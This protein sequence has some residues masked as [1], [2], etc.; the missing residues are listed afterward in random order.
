MNQFIQNS[1]IN[2][3]TSE[4]SSRTS[5]YTTQ[6]STS[7]APTPKTSPTAIPAIK[8]SKPTKSNTNPFPTH[9]RRAQHYKSKSHKQQAAKHKKTCNNQIKLAIEKLDEAKVLKSEGDVTGAFNKLLQAGQ[10]LR[11]VKY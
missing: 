8:Y 11:F 3:W 9:H 4:S 6:T 1:Q 2:Q 10:C 5:Q 7:H